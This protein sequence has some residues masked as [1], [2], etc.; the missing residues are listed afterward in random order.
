MM[1]V[2]IISHSNRKKKKRFISFV[3]KMKFPSLFPYIYFFYKTRRARDD[4]PYCFISAARC[5]SLVEKYGR[6]N[7][8]SLSSKRVF[9]FLVS[10]FNPVSS[11]SLFTEPLRFLFLSSLFIF[12]CI[13]KR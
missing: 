2:N 7:L 9:R 4:I 11:F 12:C 1:E 13:P 5:F 6:E 10:P 3:E 8:L